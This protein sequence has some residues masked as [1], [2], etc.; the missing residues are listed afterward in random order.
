VSIL[1]ETPIK[2]L[3]ET[4]QAKFEWWVQDK[5]NVLPTDPRFLDL[6]EEQ[7]DLMYAHRMRELA[8]TRN[9]AY[10]DSDYDKEEA[11]AEGQNSQEGNGEAR[12]PIQ[13]F[14]SYKDPDFDDE[15]NADDGEDDSDIIGENP[16][17]SDSGGFD[18][19]DPDDWEEVPV[20]G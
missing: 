19:D 6:T 1:Q 3:A 15:W 8:P 11:E 2:E 16:S 5:F 18:L 17:E 7:L 9:P 20:N 4:P 10:T 13:D 14:E 12:L